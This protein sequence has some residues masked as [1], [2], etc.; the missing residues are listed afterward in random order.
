LSIIPQAKA[1]IYFILIKVFLQAIINS[2]VI[3]ARETES[4]EQKAVKHGKTDSHEF[5]SLKR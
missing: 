3:G 4:R 1:A 2:S 5:Q